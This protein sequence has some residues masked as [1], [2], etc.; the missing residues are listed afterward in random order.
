M[1]ARRQWFVKRPGDGATSPAGLTLQL[2]GAA[3]LLSGLYLIYP[4][5]AYLVGG[6]G[7]ILIGEKL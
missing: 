1:V 3:A 4:P 2:L 7:A 6:S 5:L